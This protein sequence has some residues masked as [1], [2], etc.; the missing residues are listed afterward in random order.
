MTTPPSDSELDRIMEA[1]WALRPSQRAA[2]EQQ[3]LTELQKLPSD[4]RG[5]GTLHRTIAT[6]QRTFLKSGRIAIGP[7]PGNHS[8]YDRPSA[9]RAKNK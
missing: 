1:A 4:T 7:S 8:K 2:F 6:V 9:L 3:C 5:P